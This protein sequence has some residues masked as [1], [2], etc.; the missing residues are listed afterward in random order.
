L[1]PLRRAA[2]FWVC[3]FVAGLAHAADRAA[4]ELEHSPC[5]TYLPDHDYAVRVRITDQ[6]PLFDPKVI[7]RSPPGGDWQSATLVGGGGIYH[8]VIPAGALR[9]TL[10]YFIE[11]FDIQGNGPARYGT[12]TAPARVKPHDA[13]VICAQ[14]AGDG[15]GGSAGKPAAVT[16][17]RHRGDSG[18]SHGTG[19]AATPPADRAQRKPPPTEVAPTPPKKTT[20]AQPVPAAPKASK[21]PSRALA[22]P[23][24]AEGNACDGADRPLYCEPVLWGVVGGVVVVAVVI[25]LAVGL[26]SGSAPREKADVI[27]VTASPGQGLVSW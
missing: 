3:T 16:P 10:E 20:T 9:G 1:I 12:R 18:S 7:Y 2:V 5:S 22:P 26:S 19:T 8:A 6:S 13:A 25:G 24:Q 4:P 14:Y 11:A 17:P 15:E 23:T 27:I 21:P